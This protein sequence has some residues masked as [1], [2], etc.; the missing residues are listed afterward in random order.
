[1][2]NRFPGRGLPLVFASLL[3]LSALGCQDPAATPTPTN[4]DDGT[5]GSVAWYSDAAGTTA[6]SAPSRLSA[7]V[8]A[9]SG[10]A[11]SVTMAAT[12][13]A[14]AGTY[15]FKL[16]E[17]TESSD[18]ASLVVWAAGTA[19]TVYVGTQWGTSLSVNLVAETAST[20]TFDISTAR[21]AD[22]TAG[23]FSWY[24]DATGTAPA[25]APTGISASVTNVSS[26]AAKITMSSSAST[27]AGPYYFRLSEG[28]PLSN[29]KTLVVNPR[30][31]SGGAQTGSITSGTAGS[32]TFTATTNFLSTFTSKNLPWWD[33]TNHVPLSSDPTG[34][35]AT[36]TVLS[37]NQVRIAINAT[38][39]ATKGNYY[40]KVTLDSVT[41]AIWYVIVN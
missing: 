33:N 5:A 1:M 40:F 16:L 19:P 21:V 28:I 18:A 4:V 13:T 36:F 17:G 39:A 22:G 11:A 8:S 30:S 6:A 34:L 41:S 15:Y 27:V 10:N 14:A 26:N 9:V 25:A 38:T 35:S 12:A 29:L 32:A 7:A 31:V 20:I 24:A 37:G 23:G 3:G 2:K